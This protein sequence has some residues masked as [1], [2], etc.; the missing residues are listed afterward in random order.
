MKW[1]KV[2]TSHFYFEEWA[3][4]LNTTWIYVY[5]YT[6]SGYWQISQ[7]GHVFGK[8][9]PLKNAKLH[10]EVRAKQHLKMQI[11][12]M[13]TDLEILGVKNV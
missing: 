6:K 5:K 11:G 8:H 3:A 12:P 7:F 2:T 1:K 13:Q 9:R 10:A 4:E